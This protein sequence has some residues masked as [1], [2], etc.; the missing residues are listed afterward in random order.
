LSLDSHQ[1][2]SLTMMLTTR[3]K[4]ADPTTAAY[5]PTSGF[6]KRHPP[7]PGR[8]TRRRAQLPGSSPL[9]T[10]LDWRGKA[11]R[12]LPADAQQE[13][14]PTRSRRSDK[15][16]GQ[17]TLLPVAALDPRPEATNRKADQ[18]AQAPNRTIMAKAETRAVYPAI[19]GA[20]TLAADQQVPEQVT[21]RPV[22][23]KLKRRS[24]EKP[25][26]SLRRPATST[27]LC[28]AD[29][30]PSEERTEA[31]LVQR[32]DAPMCR[33]ANQVSL[34]PIE[35][36]AALWAPSRPDSAVARSQR[37]RYITSRGT[38]GS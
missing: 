15:T 3:T 17:K 7:V 35:S 30:G 21:D 22:R 4:N 28:V 18:T 16:P 14:H 2:L 10:G 20:V 8:Q 19:Q 13:T 37:K 31:A 1:Q 9:M 24:S 38:T 33:K 12:T 36:G 25:A 29:R 34:V 23:R 32:K 26:D 11:Q 5:K 6:K 27:D